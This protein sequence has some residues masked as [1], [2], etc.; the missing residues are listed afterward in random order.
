MSTRSV[1]LVA[2]SLA[3]GLAPG[4]LGLAQ[5]GDLHAVVTDARNQP[6]ADA[7]VSAHPDGK[8]VI[9][10]TTPV[11]ETVDQINMEFVPAVKPILVG[12]AVNF[13]N[14]DNIRHHVYS[15][16]PAKRFEL[17][18]YVGT[19]AEPVVFDRTGVV[20]IGCNIHDWMIGRIYVVDTPYFGKTGDEGGVRLSNL[21]AGRYTVRLWHPRM[22]GVEESTA[23]PTSIDRSGTVDVVWHVKLKPEVRPRRAPIPGQSG[24]R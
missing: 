2:A 24:Y 4:W 17:P 5:A 18:L 8:V 7:V 11:R 3:L 6:I 10:P 19:P 21:P 23:R 22:D 12:S 20:T 15:F 16:S 1:R 13:P 14:K 9:P